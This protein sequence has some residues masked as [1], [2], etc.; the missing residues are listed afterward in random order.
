MSTGCSYEGCT[1]GETNLCALERDPATCPN[2]DGA[3]IDT[4][5]AGAG[6]PV[7]DAPLESPRFPSSATLGPDVIGTMMRS[8]HIRI[9]GILGD[10]D[11]GKTAC[12]ASLYLLVSN[13]KLSGWRFADSRS[14]M[15]FEEIARGARA[16]N[17]GNPPEQMTV[18]TEMADERRPGFLHLRLRHEDGREIDMALPDLPGEWTKTLVRSD[19]TDRLEF[20]RNAEVLWLVADGRQL[21]DR[22]QRQVTITR[23]GQL[24]GRLRAMLRDA[25]PP[26]L[27]VLTHR[28]AGEIDDKTRERLDDEFQK[29]GLNVR[30]LAV[31]PF[32]DN[33]GIASGSG[34]AELISASVERR[35]ADEVFYPPSD[36]KTESRAFLAY[37]RVS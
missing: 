14:L 2:R 35:A 10:P 17:E 30:L 27:L 11:A 23:L 19:R 33:D 1:V 31:A 5:V 20:L 32:S 6:A 18:H 22:Q 7:L 16:W 36:A 24:G 37:R 3:V 29:H 26:V 34:L 21:I 8:R 9:V 4:D 25:L 12:L 28:D 15:G 13:A